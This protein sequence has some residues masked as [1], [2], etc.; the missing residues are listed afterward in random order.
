[1]SARI[2]SFPEHRIVRRFDVPLPQ[3]VKEEVSEILAAVIRDEAVPAQ[4][5]AK[6]RRKKTAKAVDCG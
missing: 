4:A 5:E 1:M 6:K 2:I 3:N